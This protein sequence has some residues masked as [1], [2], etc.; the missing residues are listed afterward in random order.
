M[1]GRVRK[2][3]STPVMTI[4]NVVQI[5]KVNEEIVGATTVSANPKHANN[6]AAA[7]AVAFHPKNILP[8]NPDAKLKAVDLPMKPTFP[9]PSYFY[10]KP[11]TSAAAVAA[12]DGS[13]DESGHAPA[14]D[15][16]VERDVTIANRVTSA[17]EEI[18]RRN[19]KS[20]NSL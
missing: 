20:L 18:R 7:A 9:L 11:T 4:G 10:F 12:H 5:H 13:D 16:T 3:A 8:L 6:S 14:E 17:V 19:L 2:R 15:P 1:L